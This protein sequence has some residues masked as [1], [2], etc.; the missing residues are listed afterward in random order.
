MAIARAIV[1]DPT[2]LLCDEPTGDLDRK[3]ADEILDLLERLVQ[4]ATA[5]RSSW[6]PTTRGRGA[7]PRDAAP[8]QGRARGRRDAT[9]MKY[10]PLLL[11]NL[12]R[13]EG[14]HRPH[15][16]LVRGGAVPVLP[17]RRRS[18]PPSTRAW[19]WPAPTG[20]WSSTRSRSS[21][22]CPSPTATGSLR[23]PGVKQVTFANWFGGVYQDEKNFFPQFAIDRETYR[24]MYTEFVVPDDQW[25]AFLA[26]KAGR[27]RGRGHWPSASAGRWATASRSRARSSR[28]TGSSTSAASTRGQRPQ[29]RHHAVL[30]PLGLPRREGTPFAKGLVGWYTVRI[31]DP[32]DAVQR[33][34]R[35]STRAS[36]T[37]PGR[38][39]PRPRRRSWPPS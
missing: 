16:G 7:R 37:R 22:R 4:R 8:R 32:D 31:A 3:S 38:P 20:W 19:R 14:P 18:A 17:A 9:A 34:R 36:P 29:R 5:R 12:L 1:A 23:I 35:P 27:D 2:F 11:A 21:S 6:S 15:R 24:Q 10:L 25:Q 33:G 30:V 39:R 26:D 13:Q 28:A